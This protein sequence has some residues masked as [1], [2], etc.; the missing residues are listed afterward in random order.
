MSSI[1]QFYINSDVSSIRDPLCKISQ[2]ST[3]NPKIES[4]E[5]SVF[6]R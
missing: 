2:N 5:I 6:F 3:L 1:Q 4:N